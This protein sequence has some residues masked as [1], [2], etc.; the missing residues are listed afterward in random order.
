MAMMTTK[1]FVDKW[2]R[3]R[4]GEMAAAQSHF[5]DVCELVEH[6]KPLEVDPEGQFFTFEATTYKVGGRR[7][8]ADV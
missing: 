7:G 8:W 4:V 2:S 1:Q 6:R 5:S 3:I